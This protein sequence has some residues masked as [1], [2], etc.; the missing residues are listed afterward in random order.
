MKL[1][2]KIVRW[3]V[4]ILFIANATFNNLH[5]AYMATIF[6]FSRML[7][8]TIPMVYLLSAWLGAPG[9]LAG[10]LAGAVIFG[11][12]ALATAFWWLGR[13]Q[14]AHQ[15]SL[16]GKK[17]R[18]EEQV[19]EAVDDGHDDCAQWAFSS[20]QTLLSQRCTQTDVPD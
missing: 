5:L 2:D 6:N 14:R 12:L 3:F 20:P 16:E 10:E 18:V 13:I 19:G 11:S 4:G 17:L 8:G 7:L 1:A 9:V 15:A